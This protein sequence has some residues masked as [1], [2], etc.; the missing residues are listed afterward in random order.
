MQGEEQEKIF[1]EVKTRLTSAAVFFVPSGTK[2]IVIYSDASK[3]G[4]GCV[5]MQQ[6]ELMPMHPDN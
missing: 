2:G 5:L 4:L 6:G 1:L 3:L